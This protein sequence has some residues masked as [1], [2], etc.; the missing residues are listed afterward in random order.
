M[1]FATNPDLLKYMPTV[2]E[3]GV[4]DWTQELADA[5]D[6]IK[7]I[8]KTKWFF[9]EFGSLRTRGMVQQPVYDPTLLVA[10]QW[11][12]ATCYRA[13]CA[14]I[15][16]KL[17]TFRVEGDVFQKQMDF[18]DAR[19]DEEMDLQLSSGVKYDLNKDSNIGNA[20]EFPTLT[21]RMYR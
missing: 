6:D 18:F 21:N 20:E 5:E 15:L 13:L 7:L 12:K 4:T 10:S 1:T 19:F 16:P 8:V 17:S 11:N 9:V 3:H 14:Y 2:M